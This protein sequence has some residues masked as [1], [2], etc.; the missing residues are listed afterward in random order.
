MSAP[1]KIIAL[2]FTILS[3]GPALSLVDGGGKHNWRPWTWRERGGKWAIL[4]NGSIMLGSTTYSCL[5]NKITSHMVQNPNSTK[6][7]T[8]N[9]S[10]LTH[11][12]SAPPHKL[13]GLSAPRDFFPWWHMHIW[14]KYELSHLFTGI[15]YIQCILHTL[16]YTSFLICI[17]EIHGRAASLF[18]WLNSVLLYGC[19]R[20]D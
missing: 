7:E 14:A 19:T 11:S 3:R 13:P 17:L 18:L 9:P 1:T 16:F 10:E 20:I 5:F 12:P 4:V 15:Y 8:V 2:Y 6:R